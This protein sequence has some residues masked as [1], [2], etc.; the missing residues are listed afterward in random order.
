M[1]LNKTVAEFRK[2]SEQRGRTAKKAITL[3]TAMTKK[4]RQF[5]FSRK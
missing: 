2:N 4:G 3:Q 1:K 5:F